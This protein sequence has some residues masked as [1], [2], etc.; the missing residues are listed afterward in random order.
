MYRETH[1]G[2]IGLYMVGRGLQ[3]PGVWGLL[4]SFGLA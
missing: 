4:F 2:A 1:D 3:G